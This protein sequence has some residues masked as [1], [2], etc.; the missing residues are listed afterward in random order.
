MNNPELAL[1]KPET[2]VEQLPYEKLLK[3][4]IDKDKVEVIREL[5]AMWLADKERLAETRFNEAMLVVQRQIPPI[6][7][8]SSN[9]STNSK[10]ARLDKLQEIITPIAL[11]NGFSLSFGTDQ[12]ALTDHYGVTCLVCHSTGDDV[13]HKRVYRCDVPCDMYG[14]KGQPNKTKTHGFGSALSYGERYLFKL[15]FNVR[16]IGEDDDG[17]GGLKP[18]PQGPSSIAG[19]SS[20]QDLVRQL[21]NLLTPVRG[22]EKNWQAANQWL[23]SQ[24]ILDGALPEEAPKL[25]A[26][27]LQEVIAK[28]KSLLLKTP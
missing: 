15:I 10:F 4:A 13:C 19:E 9:P 12:S 6:V 20:V 1:T 18:K 27:R 7:K 23:W 24:E 16:L 28:S 3:L 5:R 8:E 21:W 11:Q 26:K 17:N 22:T 2:A 25:T 14:P